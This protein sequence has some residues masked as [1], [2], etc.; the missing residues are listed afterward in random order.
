MPDFLIAFFYEMFCCL[1]ST[2]IIIHCN[3]TSIQ[4]LADSIEKN[5][6][7][8]SDFDFV[9]LVRSGNYPTPNEF[10]VEMGKLIR[11]ARKEMGL[12][13]VELAELVNRRPATISD[14]ENGKS[15]ISVITLAMF[16]A[17]LKK[18]VSY[19]F[20]PSIL[21]DF[22]LDINTPFEREVLD[23]LHV[24]SF[25]G[26]QKLVMDILNVL[27]DHFETKFHDLSNDPE[28]GLSLE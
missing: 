18:P 5:Q 11:K 19:F 16:A 25:Y 6:K 15:E 21:S 26:D 2:G 24:Y 7:Y 1:K 23:L 17:N 28:Q 22:V 9:G 10:T 3:F 20:P 13:Q 4:L 12:S 27:N 8:P 14:I